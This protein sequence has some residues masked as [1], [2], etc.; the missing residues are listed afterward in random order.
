MFIKRKIQVGTVHN[1]I[2]RLYEPILLALLIFGYNF[3]FYN[4]NFIVKTIAKIYC[5]SLVIIVTYAS[6]AC[7]NSQ[8][9]YQVWS[10]LEYSSSVLIILFFR[11]KMRLFLEKLSELD[12]CL[13]IR[14]THYFW[15]RY[16]FFFLTFLIW[17]VRIYY[18]YFYCSYFTCYSDIS[19]YL[20]S[21]LSP[22]AL[23]LNRVWRCI[24]F[25][26]IRYR[27]KILRVRLQE[28]PKENFYLYI[29]DNKS[30]RE[31]KIK[32]CLKLYRDI[33]DLVEF[34]SPELH[35]SVS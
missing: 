8:D 31:D 9:V 17:A 21:M 10:P 23:D 16:K 14:R 18:S 5:F 25:E 28:N 13:R 15:D 19:L 12:V 27:L 33:A 22:L 24:L 3:D 6:L 26:T 7:C 32:F 4:K 1:S 35:A 34:V 20:V 11:S 30:I 2:F 29:K